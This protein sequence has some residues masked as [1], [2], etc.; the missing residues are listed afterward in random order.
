MGAL[1]ETP[2]LF[3]TSAPPSWAP[4]RWVP[5]GKLLPQV[6]GGPLAAS[7][8]DREGLWGL[9]WVWEAGWERI[10]LAQKS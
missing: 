1:P 6:L 7:G 8:Q 5:T 3:S 10:L 9:W 2:V 4:A